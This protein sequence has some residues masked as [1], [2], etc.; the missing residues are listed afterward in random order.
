[1][2]TPHLTLAHVSLSDGN[3]ATPGG[4]S[5]PPVT[6]GRLLDFPDDP[7]ACMKKLQVEHG[8]VCALEEG[9]SLIH[10]SEPTRPY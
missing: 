2:T 9:L 3:E 5:R 7:L 8:N 1:M 4:A 6:H 10:I